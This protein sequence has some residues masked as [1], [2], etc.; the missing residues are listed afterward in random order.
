VSLLLPH[1]VLE[2]L[3]LIRAKRVHLQAMLQSHPRVL[4]FCRLLFI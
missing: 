3:H 4:S 2:L 1:F